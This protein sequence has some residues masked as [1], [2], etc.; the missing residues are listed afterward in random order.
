MNVLSIIIM[1]LGIG[2]VAYL[3][4]MDNRKAYKQRLRAQKMYA[5]PMFQELQPMLKPFRKAPFEQLKVD[6]FGVYVRLVQPGGEEICY[7]FDEHGYPNLTLERQEAL[8]TLLESA[9]PRITDSNQYHLRKKRRKMLSGK[10]EY[11]F[12]YI[13]DTDYKISLNR[14]PYYD[15]SLQTTQRG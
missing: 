2:W 4:V 9:L 8:L 14:A 11:I 6:R 3:I 1:L 12:A 7:R 15:S 10:Y 5:S 13:I